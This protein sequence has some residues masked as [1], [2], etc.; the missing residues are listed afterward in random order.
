MLK[1]KDNDFD[2]RFAHLGNIGIRNGITEF[3]WE[4]N[5]DVFGTSDNDNV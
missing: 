5:F 4:S 3:N 2:I 1:T